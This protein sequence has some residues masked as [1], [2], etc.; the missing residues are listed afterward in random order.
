M[1]WKVELATFVSLCSKSVT[2]TTQEIF[3]RMLCRLTLVVTATGTY[4]QSCTNTN[5]SCLSS[6]VACCGGTAVPLEMAVAS[7]S[8]WL[9]AC[10]T[11]CIGVAGAM[12]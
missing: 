3:T 5:S 9:M 2:S 8:V 10:C 1:T 12:S 4:L 7:A 11:V 6:L